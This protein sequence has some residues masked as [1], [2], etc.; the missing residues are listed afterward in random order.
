MPLCEKCIHKKICI[1]EDT[2]VGD[3][4]DFINKTDI[5]PVKHGHWAKDIEERRVTCTNCGRDF[6][7]DFEIRPVIVMKFKYCPDCG[8][9][10][11]KG[12]EENNNG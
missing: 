2:Y 11:D 6:D 5:T 3:C 8:A 10:I 1:N 9:K 4:K 7:M 12:S